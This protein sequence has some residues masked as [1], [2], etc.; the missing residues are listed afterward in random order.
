MKLI[1][2]DQLKKEIS[3]ALQLKNEKSESILVKLRKNNW[4]KY[5][6]KGYY[7]I[8][9]AEEREGGFMKY[10]TNETIFTVL[11]KLNI[12]WYLGL[13]SALIENKLSWSIISTHTIINNKISGKRNIL[14]VNYKFRKLKKEYI[15]IGLLSKESKNRKKIYYSDIE[16]TFIDYIYFKKKPPIELLE[17]KNT[18]KVEKYLTNYSKNFRKKVIK[19]DEF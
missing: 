8:L 12:D 9:D 10:S 2:K 1:S 11:N 16:K 17:K 7:Y 3:I 5:V 6:F 4:I 14:G 15:K 18:N 13:N 19:I